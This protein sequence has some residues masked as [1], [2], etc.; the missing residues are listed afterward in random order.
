MVII[1]ILAAIAIPK[2][3]STKDKAKLASA[4]T[5]IRNFMT[6]QEAYFSDNAKYAI[7][8]TDLTGGTNPLMS[9]SPGNTASLASAGTSGYVVKVGNSTISGTPKGC[10]VT[11]NSGAPATDE[12]ITCTE[13]T[14][15]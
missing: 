2:F 12:K 5:D 7:V 3:S 14:A 1:G 15:P 9:L 11:V 8:L 6:A 4:K 13:A 10:A